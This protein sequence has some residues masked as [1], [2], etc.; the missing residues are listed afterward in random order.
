[1]NTRR[2]FGVAVLAPLI[3]LTFGSAAP[4]DIIVLD[5]DVSFAPT[6]VGTSSSSTA[7]SAVFRTQV[8][9]QTAT[10]NFGNP[11]DL[12][13]FN[14]SGSGDFSVPGGFIFPNT[15]SATYNFTPTA[16]GFFTSTAPITSNASNSPGT[17]NLG[18]VMG[19]PPF[20]Q[21]V[22][23]VYASTPPPASAINFGAVR[24]GQSASQPLDI[25]NATTDVIPTTLP[26]GDP[27]T[28]LT[29]EGFTITGPNAADFSFDLT[30]GSTIDSLGPA[31]A[32]L[33]TFDPSGAFGPETATL[34]IFTDQGA[35]PGGAGAS[36]SYPLQGFSAVPEPST[37]ALLAL[38]G[39]ALAGW[40]R[41][42]KRTA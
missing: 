33:V 11:A 15:A 9:A 26:A 40:R 24:P 20:A 13:D 19:S 41:W 21:G 10:G 2:W 29:L 35:P 6:R 38:G 12:A 3:L 5:A 32:Q 14:R 42:R 37:L 18:S 39:A 25:A 31:L 1:M 4:A 7:T 30:P 36:F 8:A 22:G 28:R 23:P 16:R 17:V 27:R 34:T